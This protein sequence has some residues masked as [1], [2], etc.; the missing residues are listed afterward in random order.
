MPRCLRAAR[1]P[2]VQRPPPAGPPRSRFSPFL[3]PSRQA[4]PRSGRD[5][6]L[7]LAD[8][9][10]DRSQIRALDPVDTELLD[11][12]RSADGS[13]KH[14]TAERPV[15]E[16]ARLSEVAEQP[17]REGVA[18]TPRVAHLVEGIGRRP[19]GAIRG[20]QQSAI[21]GTFDD[22]GAWTEPEYLLGGLEHVVRAAKLPR[23]GLVDG[24]DVDA[25]HGVCER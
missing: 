18:G 21:F 10:L 11:G 7:E 19:E 16:L 14:G 2:R 24:A 13:V 5:E 1:V 17:S 23:L 15:V 12:E 3:Q 6:S 22:H 9:P 8:A 4:V 25:G 20:E